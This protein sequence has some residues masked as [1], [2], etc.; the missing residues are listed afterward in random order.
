[1]S[2]LALVPEHKAVPYM[3]EED[4]FPVEVLEET[5]WETHFR[6][7]DPV[8]F[9]TAVMPSDLKEKRREQCAVIGDLMH[10][11]SREQRKVIRLY[12]FHNLSWNE[13]ASHLKMSREEVNHYAVSGLGKIRRLAE[14]LKVS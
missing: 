8:S 7:K 6:E 11:L 9:T 5:S 2:A 13:I 3:E 12:F 1:M 10:E 14:K 4:L